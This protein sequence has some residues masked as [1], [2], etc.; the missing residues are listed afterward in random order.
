MPPIPQPDTSDNRN[1]AEEH[2]QAMREL[3]RAVN[4]EAGIP[5]DLT[6]TI[7]ELHEMM[8]AQGVR[9]EDNVASR[10]LMRM[11]YGDDWEKE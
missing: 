1:T 7:E 4:A 2:R 11:R 8:L 5:D 9:P 6:I 10:E 3:A